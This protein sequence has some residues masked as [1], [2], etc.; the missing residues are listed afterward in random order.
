MKT[1][2]LRRREK[3]GKDEPMLNL[4]DDLVVWYY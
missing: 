3:E 4:L 2:E 1:E